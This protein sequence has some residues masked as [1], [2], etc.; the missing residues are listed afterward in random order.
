MDF[1]ERLFGVAPDGGDGS[2]EFAWLAAIV[3]AILAVLFRGRIR[4]W[5][6]ASSSPHPK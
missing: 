3:V 5:L 1:I 6:A 2:L 4:S